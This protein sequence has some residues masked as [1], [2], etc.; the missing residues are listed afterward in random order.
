MGQNYGL[1]KGYNLK[2]RWI[3]VKYRWMGTLYCS[4][5]LSV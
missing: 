4:R 1:D 3:E 5:V 2:F